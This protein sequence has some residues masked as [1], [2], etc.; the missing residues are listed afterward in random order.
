MRKPL[1]AAAGLALVLATVLLAPALVDWN[2]FRPELADLLATAMGRDV[3][4]AGD[5]DLTLL[6]SPT[7]LAADVALSEPG[8]APG[9]PPLASVG[10][11][12]VKVRLL[13]LLAG[14]VQIE[15]LALVDSRM[16]IEFRPDGSR[17]G[18][19]DLSALGG[20]VQL[21]RMTIHRG[22]LTLEADDGRRRLDLVSIRGSVDAGGPQGP[23]NVAGSFSLDGVPLTLDVT[24]GRIA[25]GATVPVRA[26]LGVPDGKGQVRFAGVVPDGDPSRLQGD[27]RA[28]G[29]RLASLLRA[30]AAGLGRRLPEALP[31][32]ADQPFNA[33]ASLTVAGGRCTLKGI[34]LR[35]GETRGTGTLVLPAVASADDPA[36]LSLALSPLALDDWLPGS[37]AD[38]AGSGP[39]APLPLP[40]VLALDLVADHI[41]WER[42]LLRDARL[43]GRLEDGGLALETAGIVL[44]GDTVVTA[45]GRLAATDGLLRADTA[46]TLKTADLRTTLAWMGLDTADIPAERLR[47]AALAGRLAGTPAAFRLTDLAG[48]LDTTTLTGAVSWDGGER[49]VLGLNL[50]A[51]RLD[52][53]AYRPD[54]GGDIDPRAWADRL[55]TL[56]IDLDARFGHLTAGGVPVE[57][58]VLSATARDG[59]LTLRDLSAESAAGIAGRIAG[60]VGEPLSGGFTDLTVSARAETLAPLFRALALPPPVAPDRLGPVTLTARLAGDAARMVLEAEAGL[61]G[62]TVQAGGTLAGTDGTPAL[63]LK[64]RATLPDAV[65]LGR[66][67]WPDWRPAGAPGGTE[68]FAALTGT[69]PELTVDAIQGTLGQTAVTGRVALD[70]SG[71][72]PRLRASLVTG[73]L[74]LDRLAPAL[75]AAGG[76]PWD[77]SWT[78]GLDGEA[79][80]EAQALTLA[81]ATVEGASLRLAAGDG[82]LELERLRGTWRGGRLEAALRLTQPLPEGEGAFP[83]LEGDLRLE[84]TGATLPDL[85]PGRDRGLALS[86]GRLDLAMEGRGAGP[87]PAGVLRSLTGQGQVALSDTVLLGLDLGRATAALDGTGDARDAARRLAAAVAAGRTPLTRLSG[88]L[89]FAAGTPGSSGLA[90]EGPAG[91]LTVDGVLDPLTDTVRLSAAVQPAR[92]DGAPPF[93]LD[94][95]GPLAGPDR[96]LAADTLLA[97]VAG[98]AAAAPPGGDR[99]EGRGAV[100]TGSLPD[101]LKQ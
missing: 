31:A 91:S 96:T 51:D 33:A 101:R 15:K 48:S 65:R 9:R 90:A 71:D 4:I 98:R 13:P 46:V 88:D 68:L 24:T 99:T 74:D 26:T 17:I 47:S 60:R 29:E 49:P 79:E 7:L 85:P 76:S 82:G 2:R 6:P 63:D 56:D 25:P 32:A 5:V 81:G 45:S 84:L 14:R 97:W 12:E 54:G 16:R 3:T 67:W 52:L 83:P 21:D 37:P 78:R 40:A 44:P 77:L 22:T 18:P 27:L 66:L 94:L 34:D 58:L 100:P 38:D 8:A 73:P 20:T 64:L 61:L 75:A 23:F 35:V 28:E 72:L 95:T 93:S 50:A 53:D 19:I 62:G 89:A 30:A 1:T 59:A 39:T 92:P 86:G 69:W 80:I 55:E 36:R 87:D 70:R 43:R 57:G 11:V 42:A 41:V 10:T